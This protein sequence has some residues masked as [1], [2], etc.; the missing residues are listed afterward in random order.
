MRSLRTRALL[1]LCFLS[2]F[3]LCLAAWPQPA[4][5]PAAPL[6][7]KIE[8][9][10]WWTNFTPGLT[11]LLTGDNLT[12]TR[13]TTT[14][15]Q[16]SVLGSEASANG[17][18]LFV[19]LKLDRSLRPGTAKFDLRTPS[20]STTVELP[21][22]ARADAR[23]RFQGFSRDDVIYLIMPDRFADGDPSN[24]QP[25]GSTGTY[26]R[27][28]PKAYHGGDLRGVR[29]HLAYLHDLGVTTL[30]L[31][32]VWK[33]TDSD[34][35][36]YHVVDFFALDDHMGA[37][38]EYQGLVA[39]AHKL[40]MKVLMDYVANHTG[41]NHVWANDPPTPTW[42]HGTPAHHLDP[43]YTF[44][45]LVDPHASPRQSRATLEGWFAG[46]LPDIN[47]DDPKLST[48][49]AQNA[50]WWAESAQLDGFRL[51]TFPYS[52]RHF[53]SGWHDRLRQI[54]PHLNSVGEVWDTDPSITS[55]FEGD[56][57]QFDG[58]DSNLPT[59][60]DF[61]LCFALRD[62]IVKG[63][64]MGKIV[65]VLRHDSLYAHPEML[66]TFFG[67]HDTRRFLSE[68]GSNAAKLKAAFSLLLTLRGVP[69]I[70]SGDEIGMPGGDDPDNRHDFPG[71]FPGDPRDAFTPGGRTPEQ[72]DVFAHVQSLLALRKAHPALRDGRQ[73]H[74]GWDDTY[75]AF[76]REQPEEKL[77]VVYNNS[78]ASRELAIPLA[79][80]PLQGAQ[81]LQLLFGTAAA[82][83]AGDEVR[84]TLASRALAVF[85]VR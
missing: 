44:A 50:L 16:L 2:I 68:E 66:V 27:S 23:G 17:H 31:T 43:A 34:Y 24:D 82:A 22:S 79:D 58:L 3:V 25:T 37:L 7:R 26:D 67:N 1:V 10:N 74:I 28:Q 81:Q 75:Y 9:P 12:G 11:L 59:V 21:L 46:R 42:L 85:G 18:Y 71:G 41:P 13:V 39:D 45:G 35:H 56:R 30:W 8:P 64:P 55:F 76:L 47:P 54:Y 65:E 32:P 51:D 69:Q 84:V 15:K 20:G 63:Q 53:W 60:F 38:A 57:K 77:L 40:G 73:W 6:V 72:Q 83:M 14:T 78:P 5:S 62:S 49:L 19:R 29:Q 61:P 80:T 4:V 70:Y 36:G 33:N 48:Y 52:S